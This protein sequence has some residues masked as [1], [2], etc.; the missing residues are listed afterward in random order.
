MT[1]AR[2][3]RRGGID[4]NGVGLVHLRRMHPEINRITPAFLASH[5]FSSVEAYLACGR[6][7]PPGT[8]TESIQTGGGGDR[9]SWSA[10]EGAIPADPGEPYTGQQDDQNDAGTL[11]FNVSNSNSH[12]LTMTVSSSN[13]FIDHGS[14]PS[15]SG[16]EG[17]M[18]RIDGT[19]EVRSDYVVIEWLEHTSTSPMKPWNGASNMVIR[20]CIYH[21]FTTGIESSVAFTGPLT[22]HNC[23][24]WEGG[25]AAVNNK[26]GVFNIYNCTAL[27]CARGFRDNGTAPACYNCI[28]LDNNNSDYSGT[29]TGNY[30][31]SSDATAPGA[32][33]WR[34]VTSSNIIENESAGSEDLHMLAANDGSYEGGDYS[35]TIG[36]LDIDGH[37]RVDWDIG[38][39]ELIA[40][41]TTSTTTT[42]TTTSTSTSSSTTTSYV[43]T[44]TS[45]TSTSTTSTTTTYIS[46][47]TTTTSSSTT[48]SSSTTTSYVSTSTSTTSTSTT[49]SSTTSSSTTSSSTSTA[50][51]STTSSSTTSTS[52][53]TS[54]TTTSSS[55][56]TASTSTTS[57][58]SS[59]TTSTSTTSYVSTSTSTTSTSTTSTS[60]T[61]TTTVTLSQS[62]TTFTYH[63]DVGFVEGYESSSTTSTVTTQPGFAYPYG[64]PRE[65]GLSVPMSELVSV[66]LPT[67]A[68]IDMDPFSLKTYVN[69]GGGFG[70]FDGVGENKFDTGTAVYGF[71]SLAP[72]NTPSFSSSSSTTTYPWYW[73]HTLTE[74]EGSINSGELTDTETDDDV[75]I[76]LN[77]VAAATP[78]FDYTFNFGTGGDP[79]PTGRVKVILYGY[80]DGNPAHVVLIYAWNFDSSQYDRLTAEAKDMPDDS[81]EQQYEWLSPEPATAYVFNGEI[82]I[83]VSQTSTGSA[84]HLL[85]VDYL[86]L[87][88]ATTTTTTTS[89]TTTTTTTV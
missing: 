27:D 79:A 87:R 17:A 47:S 21:D 67:A 48:S 35:G 13:R 68:A 12:L 23:F 25:Y 22:L 61:S 65:G 18:A 2:I 7:V 63:Y 24:F 81:S 9:T 64:N 56:T 32:T 49:S 86:R 19:V 62:T 11:T 28:S 73:A 58:S 75:E 55:T 66:V 37:T 38:A 4:S 29:V 54:S 82:R 89:T 45:T 20:Y 3:P 52:T 16:V 1:G 36:S 83:R 46:S 41:G 69:F 50:S 51:S 31:M 34:S 33:N 78:G 84:G 14:W 43:S 39:D 5:G 80:Y 30:N 15:C 40:A 44:S 6:A 77:E 70:I 42:S 76:V 72:E 10:W 8:V 85:H 71:T 26:G 59:T 53:T 74:T 57:T 60:T 88:T